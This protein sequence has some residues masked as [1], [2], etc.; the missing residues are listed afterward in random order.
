MRNCQIITGQFVLSLCVT[1]WLILAS[2]SSFQYWQ[3][4]TIEMM[5]AKVGEALRNVGSSAHPT[6]YLVKLCPIVGPFG[7]VE[8]KGSWIVD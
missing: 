2:T 7:R 3:T 4:R 6:D 5:Y 1:A 8:V